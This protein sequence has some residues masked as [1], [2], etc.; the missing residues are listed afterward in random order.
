MHFMLFATIM[1]LR[2]KLMVQFWLWITY[3]LYLFSKFC[4]TCRGLWGLVGRKLSSF[5]WFC[6]YNL[7]VWHVWWH[8]QTIRK[9]LSVKIFSHQFAKVFTHKSFLLYSSVAEH[10]AAPSQASWLNSRWLQPFHS[11][12]FLPQNINNIL[13]IK[14]SCDHDGAIRFIP[15]YIFHDDNTMGSSFDVK[16]SILS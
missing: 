6:G 12:L 5:L 15:F 3:I 2:V 8:Q 13:S 9:I 11:P 16:S 4:S 10:M 1:W 7:G 14:E